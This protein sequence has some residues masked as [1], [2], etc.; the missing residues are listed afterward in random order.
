MKSCEAVH[1]V[2]VIRPTYVMRSVG[3]DYGDKIFQSF[4]FTLSWFRPA[5]NII[6]Q[7]SKLFSETIVFIADFHRTCGLCHQVFSGK[8]ATS[9]CMK[10]LRNRFPQPRF[11]TLNYRSLSHF[12]AFLT[13]VARLLLYVIFTLFI[14]FRTCKKLI[15][16]HEAKV[17][18]ITITLNHLTRPKRTKKLR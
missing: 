2:W 6:C 11:S 7:M 16:K 9:G 17:E 10:L 5:A 14:N 13:L 4:T 18:L 12:W 3:N 8:I 1:D 15:I